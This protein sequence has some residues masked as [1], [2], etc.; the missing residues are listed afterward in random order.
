MNI[1]QTY[2]N[3]AA[4]LGDIEWKLQQLSAAKANVLAQINKL[5]ELAVMQK[6]ILDEKKA[7]PEASQAND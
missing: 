2:S 7:K 3:L 1:D 5:N 6:G 4:Q